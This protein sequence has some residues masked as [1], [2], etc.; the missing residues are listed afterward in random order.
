MD[1]LDPRHFGTTVKIRDTSAPNTVPKCLG[2][3]VSV[4]LPHSRTVDQETPIA[5]RTSLTLNNS[6]S[7]K[8]LCALLPRAP[9]V[10]A[11]LRTYAAEESSSD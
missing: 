7:T 8:L 5:Y 3:E 4:H 1:T 11:A 9:V 6:Y 10:P 2:S